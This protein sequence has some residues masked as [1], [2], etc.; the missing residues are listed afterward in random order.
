MN[1]KEFVQSIK[2]D[3]LPKD[4]DIETQ[5]LWIER[6]GDWLEAHEMVQSLETRKAFWVHAYLHRREGDIRNAQ[7][8]YSR[9]GRELPDRSLDEEWRQIAANLLKN[10][11]G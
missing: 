10:Q 7:Y 11:A 6:S 9:A 2:E 8:W 4:L 1:I 5:A 3:R